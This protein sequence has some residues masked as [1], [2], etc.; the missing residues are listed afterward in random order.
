M[1]TSIVGG[2]FLD[3]YAIAYGNGDI[4]PAYSPNFSVFLSMLTSSD[5]VIILIS[6]GFVV[7]SFGI[8]YAVFINS[9]R[10]MMAMGLD[11]ALPKFFSDVS[12]R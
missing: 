8:G 12:P 9:S 6:L 5:I 10:V 2:R 3:E 1:L 7:S 4:A 11:G